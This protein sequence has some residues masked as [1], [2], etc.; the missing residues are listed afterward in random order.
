MKSTIRLSTLYNFL[1]IFAI[2]E[3]VL[4]GSGQVIR[5][6]GNLTLRMFNYLCIFGAYL[7]FGIFGQFKMRKL[8][9]I[10]LCFFIFTFVYGISISFINDNTENLFLD[11][12]SLSYFL[13]FPFFIILINSVEIIDRITRIIKYGALI[14]SLFYLLYLVAIKILD[15]ID[16][17]TFYGSMSEQSDIMFRGETGE[18]FYKGFLFLPIGML[19]WLKDK[20]IFSTSII[21]VAIF[22]TLTRG[23]YIMALLGIGYIVVSKSRKTIR[24][25]CLWICGGLA[26]ILIII[27]SGLFEMG[28]ARADGDLVRIETF[29]Q[30][31]ERI[32]PASILIGHGFGAG[33]P[34]REIHMENAFLEIFHKQGLLGIAFWLFILY[35][36]YFFYRHCTVHRDIAQLYWIG[37]VMVYVQSLLNPFIS[38]SIGMSFIIISYGCCRY[39][40]QLRTDEKQSILNPNSE[41]L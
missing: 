22:F 13:V 38:N 39:L 16:F 10:A 9:W 20:R 23:F 7:F 37:T 2:V 11:I 24:N 32:T 18:V 31:V 1:L 30:V 25:I 35:C 21:L 36:I 29:D 41:I 15:L 12:K 33:V 14:M 4:C 26:S 40:S 34:I 3:L 19:F 6:G 5:M 27:A 28:E 8:D 17:V